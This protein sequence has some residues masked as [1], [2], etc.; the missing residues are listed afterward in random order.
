[1]RRFEAPLL[2]LS[3]GCIA[4]P[5]FVLGGTGGGGGA[6]TST[7]TSST[8]STS[9]SASSTSGGE[10]GCANTDFDPDNC[11]ACGHVCS[12]TCSDGKCDPVVL[13]EGEE[14]P[15]GIIVDDQ[16]LYW[17]TYGSHLVR[18]RAKASDATPETV[19]SMQVNAWGLAQDATHLYWT[20]RSLGTVSR[21]PKDLSGDVEVLI[22]GLSDPIELFVAG[23]TLYVTARAGGQVVS[24]PKT[25]G[26]HTVLQD[27]FPE[28][29]GVAVVDGTVMITE[30]FSGDLLAL[31]MNGPQVLADGLQ[32][33][34]QIVPAGDGVLWCAYGNDDIRYLPRGAAAPQVLAAAD[35]CWGVFADASHVYWTQEFYEMPQMGRVWMGSLDGSPPVMVA[36]GQTGPT[37]ITADADAIYWSNFQGGQI[38]RVDK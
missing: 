8:T 2:F 25:G 27:G 38:V 35:E 26:T 16:Y 1:M 36:D 11:G 29:Y 28:P 20:S 14:A 9:T 12:D 24:V 21:L 19:A 17:V 23:D 7:T 5:T 22:S 4:E 32:N 33:A 15:R 10:G 6:G 3:I 13:V 31:G 18:R 30:A 37:G 34:F